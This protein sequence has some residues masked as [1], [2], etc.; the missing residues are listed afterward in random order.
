MGYIRKRTKKAILRYYLDTK[1]QENYNRGLLTLF[2]PFRNEDKDIVDK[3]PI[4][5]LNRV[6]S[7]PEKKRMFEIQ[8][9]TYQPYRELVDD[10]MNKVSE[11]SIEENTD[12]EELEIED[13]ELSNTDQDV[14]EE[15]TNP[16]DINEWLAGMNSQ[17]KEEIKDMISY[18]EL[19]KHVN[20]LNYQQRK[21][22][23]DFNN[24]FD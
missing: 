16:S 19:K 24:R 21:V 1:N 11:D 14:Q 4:V 20:S 6:L 15:T 23:D 10:L 12:D 18:E 2:C 17:K 8:L 13:S 5:E 22:F 7:N 3:D 9:K